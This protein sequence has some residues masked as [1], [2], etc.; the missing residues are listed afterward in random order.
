MWRQWSL[1]ARLSASFIGLFGLIG[2][3]YVALVL[4]SSDRYYDE[5]TQK[6]NRSLAMYIVN[7]APLIEHGQVNTAAMQ[8]LAGLVMVVPALALPVA[9][10]VFIDSVLIDQRSDWFR[11]LLVFMV[12]A[13]SLKVAIMLLQL[14]VGRRFN[15]AMQAKLNSKF[16]QHLFRIVRFP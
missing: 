9:T 2:V 4:W 12:A 3:S 5:I 8:E 6:L 11:P 1:R 10:S 16:I 13:L 7:R 14:H 15:L